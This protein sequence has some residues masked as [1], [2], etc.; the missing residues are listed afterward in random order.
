MAE[1]MLINDL[2]FVI[3]IFYVA[4]VVNHLFVKRKWV[5]EIRNNGINFLDDQLS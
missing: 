1:I 5:I 3:S 2:L 4:K